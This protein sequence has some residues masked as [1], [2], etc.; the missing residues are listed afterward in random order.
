MPVSSKPVR[1]TRDFLPQEVRLRGYLHSVILSTYLQAGFERIYTPML[2]S[3]ERLAKSDGGE[4][5]NMIFKVLKRGNKLDLEKP[6]LTEDDLCDMGL[7]Y[8]LTLPLVRYYANN[9]N[10]LHDPFKC[11]QVDRVFRAERPQ[12][13]RLREFYQCDIDIIGDASCNA[14]VE[15]IHTTTTALRRLGFDDFIVR[16][17]DR[18]ILHDIIVSC[19]FGEEDVPGVC[20]TFDKLDKVGLEGVEAELADKG[21]DAETIARFMTVASDDTLDSVEKARSFVKD[22][23]VADDLLYVID[24]VTELAGDAYRISY[25]KSLV[26]GM[27]YYTG[28]VFEIVTPRFS[29]SI[30]G[31]GRYD[32]MAGKFLKESVPAVGFSIGFERIVQIL[33]ESGFQVPDPPHRRALLYPADADFT[34]VIRKADEM[35]SAGHQV[36]IYAQAKK[37]GKQLY[38]LEEDGFDD[39]YLFG[40][41]EVRTFTERR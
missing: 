9:R 23:A 4:N 28:M 1:G 11:I 16:I 26:R 19:G 13:G 40:S 10:E 6:D 37:L 2:E 17:N 41:D 7:R 39:A 30:A 22:T 14:E 3:S 38:R 8:D 15:L 34:A 21:Y 20:I 33:L 5:L 12:R 29:S 24:K 18:R 27:G 25:D 32:N 35:R 31:G 36:A